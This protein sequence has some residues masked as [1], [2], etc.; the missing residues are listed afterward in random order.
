MGRYMVTSGDTI[1]RTDSYLV[2]IR[3][4]NGEVL[5]D[6]E[7]RRLFPFSD[8]EHYITFLNSDGKEIALLEDLSVMPEDS[9][10]AIRSCFEDCYLIPEIT[11]V[12]K[13]DDRNGSFKWVVAT[14]KGRVEFHIRNRHSDIKQLDNNILLRDSNDNR[15][16]LDLDKLDE[17]SVKK[18]LAYI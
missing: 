4:S 12:I 16:H 3:K 8:P 17:K 10:E 18:I 5:T 6:L 13:I 14:D 15:Y 1:N 11:E 9:V 7:P 2:S